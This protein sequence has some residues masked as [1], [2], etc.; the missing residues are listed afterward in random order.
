MFIGRKANVRAIP[1]NPISVSPKKGVSSKIGK[2]PLKLFTTARGSENFG[3]LAYF[4][5]AETHAVL[6]KMNNGFNLL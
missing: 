3:K 2:F 4:F 1:K 6:L 5:A